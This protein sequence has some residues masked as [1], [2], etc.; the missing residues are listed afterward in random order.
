M[1]TLL[2]LTS[3][4]PGAPEVDH[5]RPD[6]LVAGHP[7]RETWNVVDT[8]VGGRLYCG[9]WR[10]EVGQWRVEFGAAEH[11][12]FTVL[13]GRV[14]VLGDDGSEQSAG[15]GEA[16]YLPP[17]FSGSFEVVEPVTKSYAIV[18]AT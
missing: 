6:R 16:I 10:C 7:R 5:P 14:R 2:K 15:A 4:M 8:P 11:E 13:E 17:G 3:T 12:M 1:K 18:D 9:I